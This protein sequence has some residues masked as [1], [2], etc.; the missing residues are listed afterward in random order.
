MRARKHF[1]GS[2]ETEGLVRGNE[3]SGFGVGAAAGSGF[4][5]K[6]RENVDLGFCVV[7]AA[8]RWCRLTRS[9]SATLRA[10]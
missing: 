7:F 10:A 2:C 5:G 8:R 9:R 4:M 3:D 1:A 6:I